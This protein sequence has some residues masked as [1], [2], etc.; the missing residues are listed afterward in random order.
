MLV[1]LAEQLFAQPNEHG[2]ATGLCTLPLHPAQRG[3]APIAAF[4][5]G[6]LD[7][8]ILF[9]AVV[10][11]SAWHAEYGSNL[12]NGAANGG[13]AADDIEIDRRWRPATFAWLWTF[14]AHG[15]S[16]L[17]LGCH[18][19]GGLRHGSSGGTADLFLIVREVLRRSEYGVSDPVRN[20]LIRLQRA[21]GIIAP[22]VVCAPMRC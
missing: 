10:E 12:T 11:S 5:H 2:I 22:S 21:R 4:I 20:A 8:R 18:H 13:R 1:A 14:L 17:W 3:V 19:D 6:V 15:A 9:H 16:Q 7:F